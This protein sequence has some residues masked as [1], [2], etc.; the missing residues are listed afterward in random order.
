MA[1]G[2][3]ALGGT[4]DGAYDFNSLA[5]GYNALGGATTNA[6]ACTA[7]GNYTMTELI[8]GAENTC[9]GVGARRY[10]T[11]Y[12]L[13]SAFGRSALTGL[14]SSKPS[15]GAS[16][17]AFGAYAGANATGTL[18]TNTFIGA[19]SGYG[20]AI[21]GISGSGNAFL[22]TNTGYYLTSG[23]DN[24]AVGSAAGYRMTTGQQNVLVGRGAGYQITTGANNIAV[25]YH[26]GYTNLAT[27]AN[28]ILI[29][30]NI[31]TPASSTSNYLNIGGIIT[32]NVSTK[33][34]LVGKPSLATNATAGFLWLPTMAGTPTGTI[35]AVTGMTPVWIDSTGSKLWANI[36]G[37]LK[38]IAFT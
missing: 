3:G 25:G 28:N 33:D 35:T 7:V 4:A 5:V 36:G 30:N 23:S 15:G 29:G 22:G 9:F 34:V 12:S 14:F 6:R 32:G 20:D 2:A 16:N 13:D 8:S 19:Y 11:G 37:T 27:G 26:T 24:V 21:S 38:S 17:A 31:D 18:G 1:V 10:G